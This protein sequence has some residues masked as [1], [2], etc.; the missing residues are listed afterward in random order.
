[1]KKDIPNIWLAGKANLI[2][3]KINIK[4]KLII[5]SRDEP[6]IFAKGSNPPKEQYK[7]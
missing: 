1:M 5:Q 6:N 3:D 7:F 4:P 2:I